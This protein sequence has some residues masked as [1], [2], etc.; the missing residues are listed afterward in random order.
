MSSVTIRV[1]SDTKAQAAAIA[2]ELGTD[3]SAATRMFYKQ[4]IREQG[5]PVSLH[6]TDVPNEETRASIQE[7]RSILASDTPGKQ[8]SEEL[9][10]SLGI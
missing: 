7:G 8:S 2:E 5:I 6:L 3:L 1:D 10:D 4:M 9:F